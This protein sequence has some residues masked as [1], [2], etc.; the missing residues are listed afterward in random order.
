MDR[1]LRTVN[2]S[3]CP[4][5]LRLPVIERSGIQGF[6]VGPLSSV[7]QDVNRTVQQLCDLSG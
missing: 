2:E 5:Q 1:A 4:T 7:L 3:E 6:R